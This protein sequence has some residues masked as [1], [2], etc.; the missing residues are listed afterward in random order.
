MD[1]FPFRSPFSQFYVSHIEENC[2]D[3]NSDFAPRFYRHI[4]DAFAVFI[5]SDKSDEFLNHSNIVSV[6]LK[7]TIG[8]MTDDKVNYIGLTISKDFFQLQIKPLYI[9]YPL[10]LVMY[11]VST[12]INCLTHRSFMYTDKNCYLK[13]ELNKI[14]NS[15]SKLV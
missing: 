14:E 11:Q 10:L 3:F 5:N 15:A 2:I 12:A 9:I 13:I 8:K 1:G 6:P 7:F 4:V